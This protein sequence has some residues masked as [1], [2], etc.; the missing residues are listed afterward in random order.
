VKPVASL[1][2]LRAVTSRVVQVRRVVADA[3][4]R[5]VSRRPANGN[6]SDWRQVTGHVHAWRSH[7]Y[8]TLHTVR[9][10]R[11]TSVVATMAVNISVYTLLKLSTR[12]A[13]VELRTTTT[14]LTIGLA[15]TWRIKT[16]D[17]GVIKAASKLGKVVWEWELTLVTDRL[18]L[19]QSQGIESVEELWTIAV[20]LAHDRAI[21][22]LVD[23]AVLTLDSGV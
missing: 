5:R 6:L 21:A 17:G 3:G 12:S 22:E 4:V 7:G 2:A 19:W 16:N 23:Q 15:A 14:V 18:A 10:R 9:W 1:L 13:A 20:E 11:T 8:R